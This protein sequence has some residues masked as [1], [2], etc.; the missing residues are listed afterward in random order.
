MRKILFFLMLC[1]FA[2]RVFAAEPVRRAQEEL[3]RRNLF[4]GDVDGQETPGLAAA[5]R[6]YQSH[7]GFAPSGRLDPLTARSLGIETGDAVDV[8]VTKWP[9]VPVLKSDAAREL[10]PATQAAI[11]KQAVKNLAVEPLPEEPAE[12]P[13]GAQNL[14][15]QK[16]T[17]F[18]ENY[19]RDN[20]ANELAL[21][22]RYYSFPVDYFDHGKVGEGF[23]AKDNRNYMR[24]WPIR[25]YQ[26]E[27][28]VKFAAGAKEGETIVEFPI[29]FEVRGGSRAARGKTRNIWTIKP[30]GG[31]LKIVA[32]QEQHL[33][34]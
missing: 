16:V 17:T 27:A 7:K 20:E 23:V 3:R 26:M 9:D 11:E 30:D 19:L 28:P 14:D 24:R 5:L 10:P 1:A 6:L 31:E 15:P 33:R 34:E 4:F 18:V 21:Q 8:T 12:S 29:S 25:H 22:L 32:I 2:G 13:S